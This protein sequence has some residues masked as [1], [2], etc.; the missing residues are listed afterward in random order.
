MFAGTKTMNKK[1]HTILWMTL[2]VGI[3]LAGC[4]GGGGSSK[5]SGILVPAKTLTWAPPTAYTDNTVLNPASDLDVFEVYVKE[6][7][8]FTGSD[9][10]I[11][12]VQAVDPGTG[13]VITSFNLS[14]LS[15]FLPDNVVLYVSVRAVAKNTLK[16]DF[17]QAATFSF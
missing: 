3:C 16:S 5:D 12:A 6:D 2:A 10:A 14:N 8:I 4:G 1:L 13:Q 7:G 9:S 11:A 17:S 15:P